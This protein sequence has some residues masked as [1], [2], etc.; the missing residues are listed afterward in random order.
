[1]TFNCFALVY[2]FSHVLYLKK[3][4]IAKDSRDFSGTEEAI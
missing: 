3:K 1:M 2:Q 4:L